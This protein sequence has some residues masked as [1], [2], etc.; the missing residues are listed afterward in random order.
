MFFVS[1]QVHLESQKR[2]WDRET[3]DLTHL[4]ILGKVF[5]SSVNMASIDVVNI[6]IFKQRA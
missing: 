1:L 2:L 6:L 5:T 3:K 4:D